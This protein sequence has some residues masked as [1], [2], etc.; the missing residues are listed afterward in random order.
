MARAKIFI[1]G[2]TER[3]AGEIKPVLSYLGYDIAG[4]SSCEQEI[5]K[6]ISN[7][8]PDVVLMET[9]VQ[10]D[11]SGRSFCD[12]I[13]EKYEIPVIY[14]HSTSDPDTYRVGKVNDLWKFVR[15]PKDAKELFTTIE[16]ARY[17]FG[18]EKRVKKKEQWFSTTLRSIGDAII[19]TDTRGRITFMNCVA[20]R[21]TGWTLKEAVRRDLTKVFRVLNEE[22]RADVRNPVERVLRHG[23]IEGV[24]NHTVLITKNG[25][26]IPI[27][28]NAAPV[29]DEQEHLIGVV[30]VFRDVSNRRR[31]EKERE[32]SLSL[33]RTILESTA[34]GILVVDVEGKVVSYNEKFRELW[35][36][37]DEIIETRN[38]K[39]LLDFVLSQ[40]QYPDQFLEKIEE[41]Y[42]NGERESCDILEFADGR[43]FERFSKPQRLG[44]SIIGRVWSFRDITKGKRAEAQLR[45]SEEKFRSL[46]EDSK[47]AIFIS[48]PGGKI[49]DINQAGIELFGYDSKEELLKSDIV[50]DLYVNPD[51]RKKL[52]Q[53]L[54]GAGYVKDLE[55]TLKKKDGSKIMVQE[56]ATVER[57]DSGNVISYRGILRD[58]TEKKKAEKQLKEYMKELKIAKNKAEEQARK[59]NAQA[60]E[61]IQA[62]EAALEASRLK[63]EFVA[64][65]SHEIRTPLNGV[66]GM[67][68]ML[69]DTECTP[70]QR[71]YIDIVQKS[72]E[73]LLT[74]VNNILDFSKIEAGKLTL[75]REEFVLR[76]VVEE[77]LE[78]LAHKAHE[79]GIEVGCLVYAEAP[80]VI[81][82]DVA[83][84]HQILINLVGNAIKFTEEGE[85]VVRVRVERETDSH[86]NLLF[87]VT[88]TGIGISEEDRKKLFKP[89]TQADGSTTRR[90]GGTGLGLVIAKQLVEMMNGKIGVESRPGKGSTFWFSAEFEKQK[91]QV[92]SGIASLDN[93]DGLRVL[94]V[95]DNETN[96]EII[97]YQ[98]TSWGMRNT[99]AK[100]AHET[101]ELLHKAV[102]DNDLFDL[103]ILDM[104]MPGMDGIQ[105]ARAIKS[106]DVFSHIRLIMLTSIGHKIQDNIK[107]AGIEACLTKPVRQSE[108]YNCIAKVMGESI[109]RFDF[110]GPADQDKVAE[111]RADGQLKR[112]KRKKEYLRILVVEDNPNNQKVA[113]LMVRK[114]GH[115]PDIACNGREAV[116]ILQYVKYDMLLMDCHMPEMDGFEATA[117]IRKNEKG[118]DRTLIVAMT[119]NALKG[120]REKCIAAGMD[121]YISK[122][123]KLDDLAD[124]IGKWKHKKENK[125]TIRVE[126]REDSDA[127]RII[128][129]ENRIKEIQELSDDDDQYLLDEM[130]KTFIADSSLKLNE[131][132]ES[133]RTDDLK[134]LR[135]IGHF[136]KG[137]CG[138]LGIVNMKN[139]SS[140]L[141]E[142]G[143]TGS[144]SGAKKLLEKLEYEFQ[145]VRAVLESK[146]SMNGSLHDESSRN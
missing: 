102:E 15:E 55:V 123:V 60:I 79:K 44:D 8:R 103:V 138:N 101:W 41:L 127:D 137:S 26:E 140:E 115:R 5:K 54:E 113:A 134:G 58:V 82:G 94:T 112:R 120:D 74:I 57:D 64:N 35:N 47:D 104:Q 32:R 68:E 133:V 95:D 4:I 17:Q 124:V 109:Q 114:L 66:I 36:I 129:D 13:E 91:N 143:K 33:H 45:K 43:V 22:S 52:K 59:L 14:I 71:E 72:G 106:Q 107:D 83:R 28:D 11:G 19:V 6:R 61:L 7:Q 23:R 92:E 2:D 110:E 81:K 39:D 86:V 85:V 90:Y 34:D 99:K 21:L 100:D 125:E 3:L 88:D 122:P 146:Y 135:E 132:K 96:L 105:L 27:D 111:K 130:I 131:L 9:D 46:F 20:E 119:A 42:K 145:K 78:L 76:E 73:A 12:R 65:M 93:L 75:E 144:T 16:L 31:V 53:Q 18:L 48:T 136:L 121:D 139:I 29:R 70:D 10:L 56:T 62:R 89:F 98:V 142:L 30:L 116:E 1:I 49:V 87:T 108:L 117:E 97:H 63:S 67:T 50:K 24:A 84:L 126:R 51:D 37:P 38:D 40:L 128:I 80:A 77:S 25:N 118:H 69:K 141:E